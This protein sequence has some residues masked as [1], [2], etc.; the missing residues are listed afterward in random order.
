MTWTTRTKPS[1]SWDKDRN[2]SSSFIDDL[3]DFIDD[4][5]LMF[6]DGTTWQERGIY[7]FSPNYYPFLDT[8][9]PFTLPGGVQTTNWTE[10]TTP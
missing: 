8:G 4:Y 9:T 6:I 2:F 1:T 10:R 5:D 3:D 7:F